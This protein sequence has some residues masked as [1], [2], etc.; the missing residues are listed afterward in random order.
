MALPKL[1]AT[2]SYE[3]TIP[4]SGQKVTFRPFLVKEQR[5][6][7]IAFETQDRKDLVRAII[8][9]IEACVEQPI[10][11]RLTTFDVDYMFTLIRAK[12]VG[13]KAEIVLKCG[14]CGH[15][16]EAEVVL[17][18]VELSSE[19]QETTIKLTP[20]ITI[21]MKYPTY[22]EFLNNQ[23]LDQIESSAD[24]LI[25]LVISCMESVSTEE[26]RFSVKDEPKEEII[27]FI[28]SMS[29]SQF[30]KLTNFVNAVPAVQKEVKF[31]CT[32]CGSINDR[33]L[34]G[35]DDFFS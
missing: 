27:Q 1:N 9:T 31:V 35:M 8:R 17:E 4:S 19:I 16:N 25:E 22:E 26:E 7:L 24:M 20:E 30:E 11:Q 23:S 34:R 21:D 10:T 29:N 12:S 13:E 32:S 28:E 33:M 3:L 15:D 2:P 18:D 14:E 5:N 6:L